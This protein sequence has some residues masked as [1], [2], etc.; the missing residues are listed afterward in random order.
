MMVMTVVTGTAL[1]MFASV[2]GS[3]Q[4]DIVEQLVVALEASHEAHVI[5]VIALSLF[6]PRLDSIQT[7]FEGTLFHDDEISGALC[8][9]TTDKGAGL[10]R[11]LLWIAFGKLGERSDRVRV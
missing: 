2:L 9:S 1:T 10:A 8:Q 11:S 4:V 3:F 5:N 6:N 7:A